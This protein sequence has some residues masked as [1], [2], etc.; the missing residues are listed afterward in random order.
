MGV[1]AIAPPEYEVIITA[2]MYAAFHSMHWTSAYALTQKLFKKADDMVSLERSLTPR[3]GF[4]DILRRLR[5]AGV[6]YGIATSDTYERAIYSLNLFD[7]AD[8]VSFIITPCDV[9]QGKPD[10]EM[11][12]YI[13][14]RTGIAMERIVMIGDSVVDVEMARRTGAIGIGVPEREDMKQ[15]MLPYADVIAEDLDQIKLIE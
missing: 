3:K 2:G 12:K 10:P 4:P 7:N 9:E 11:L 8:D 5:K 13:S 1:L 6:P 15:R 14:A